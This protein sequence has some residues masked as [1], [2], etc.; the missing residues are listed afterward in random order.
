MQLIRT[1]L[2]TVQVA[3]V[4]AKYTFDVERKFSPVMTTVFPP[5]SGPALYVGVTARAEVPFATISLIV[6]P[7]T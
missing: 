1:K 7:L 2:E 5:D 3:F 6:G 4:V